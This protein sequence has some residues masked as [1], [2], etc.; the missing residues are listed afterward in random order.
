MTRKLAVLGLLLTLTVLVGCPAS[1]PTTTVPPGAFSNFDATSYESL[2]GAQAA[3]NSLK[4][5][6]ASGKLPAAAKPALNKA[7]A[8]YNAAEASW[9]AFHAAKSSDTAAVTKQSRRRL[10]T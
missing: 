9:Q 3:L 10:R 4:A 7:I 6:L 1:T 8:S 5:D 2:M